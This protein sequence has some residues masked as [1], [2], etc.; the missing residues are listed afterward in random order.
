MADDTCTT[1]RGRGYLDEEFTSAIP[2][3]MRG[4]RT[5]CPDCNPE[6]T[7]MAA[8]MRIEPTIRVTLDYRDERVPTE[9]TFSQAVVTLNASQEMRDTTL[10][11]DEWRTGEPLPE[12]AEVVLTVTGRRPMEIASEGELVTQREIIRQLRQ[13]VD[14]LEEDLAHERDA[15]TRVA[16][17]TG[18]DRGDVKRVALA[19]A[20]SGQPHPIPPKT[21]ETDDGQD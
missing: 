20:Y 4:I 9:F 7:N 11:G 21:Q 14:T 6:E 1:C 13:R 17:I 16:K 15:Y 2:E 3:H 10:P 18:L 19:L 8:T 12:T 5:R